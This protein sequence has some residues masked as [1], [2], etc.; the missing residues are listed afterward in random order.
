MKT[1]NAIYM[2]MLSSILFSLSVTAQIT[3][4][5]RRAQQAFDKAGA[6][7][8]AQ[9]YG[10]AVALLEEA[11]VLDSAFAAAYQQ[12]GD[13]HR[14]QRDYEVAASNYKKR[15]EERREGKEGDSTCRSR[16]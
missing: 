10:L 13:I 16:V 15:S 3:S 1:V 12:L 2:L 4:N 9:Q 6:Q 5:N 7:L 8:R 14:K 11:I